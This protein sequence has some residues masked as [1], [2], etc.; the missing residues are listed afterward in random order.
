MKSFESFII[1]QSLCIQ[2]SR[3]P[4]CPPWHS[5]FFV[6]PRLDCP[7]HLSLRR[8]Q[9]L[10]IDTMAAVQYFGNGTY[11]NP[12]SRRFRFQSEPNVQG[13][14]RKP[15]AE[16]VFELIER[17]P[18]TDQSPSSNSREGV[19]GHGGC[20]RHGPRPRRRGCLEGKKRTRDFL[21]APASRRRHGSP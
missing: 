11:A 7:P 8:T 4:V 13:V 2:I 19:R 20:Y 6:F 15:Y 21:L 14:Y 5:R 17:D 18:S 12:K 16:L 10:C 3:C 1:F 9:N